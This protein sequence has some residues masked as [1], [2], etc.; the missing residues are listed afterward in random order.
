MGG[1]E[2]AVF[3][4]SAHHIKNIKHG[5]G[6]CMVMLFEWSCFL[7]WSWLTETATDDYDQR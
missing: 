1:G 6:F 4:F 3:C 2:N 7:T 5:H